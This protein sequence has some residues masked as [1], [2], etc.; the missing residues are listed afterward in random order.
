MRNFTYTNETDRMVVLRCIDKDN[1]FFE[2]V[3]YPF[4]DIAFLAPEDSNLEIWGKGLYGAILEERIRLND[5]ISSL[6]A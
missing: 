3:I 1:F 6:A 2:R 4:E 5:P